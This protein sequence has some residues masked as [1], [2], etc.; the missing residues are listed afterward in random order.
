M[1]NK[2]DKE[3]PTLHATWYKIDKDGY[4]DSFVTTNSKVEKLK[5]EGRHGWQMRLFNDWARR[6]EDFVLHFELEG[7]VSSS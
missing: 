1:Q 6:V 2:G 5:T 7:N 4:K 3:I